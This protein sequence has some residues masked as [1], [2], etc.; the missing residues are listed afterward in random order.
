MIPLLIVSAAGF[1]YLAI[2]DH[3][4]NY[5]KRTALIDDRIASRRS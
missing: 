1:A 2:T 5:P 3:R 4:R